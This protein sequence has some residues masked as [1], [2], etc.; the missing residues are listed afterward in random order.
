MGKG[1]CVS[2]AYIG[3]REGEPWPTIAMKV[4]VG[5]ARS[6][7]G[8]MES[9]RVRRNSWQF[10]LQSQ[11]RSWVAGREGTNSGRRRGSNARRREETYPT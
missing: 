1:Q 10:C 5:R 3:I 6:S 4:G 11:S 7:S 8:V 9:A 2:A